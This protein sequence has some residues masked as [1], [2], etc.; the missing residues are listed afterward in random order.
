M[1]RSAAKQC[2]LTDA[3]TAEP[4]IKKNAGGSPLRRVF[5]SVTPLGRP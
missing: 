2:P 5:A 3:R 4:R 1:A